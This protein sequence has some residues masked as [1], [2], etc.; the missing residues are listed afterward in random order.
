MFEAKK[1]MRILKIL[2]LTLTSLL[3]LVLGLFGYLFFS[4]QL[5]NTE[6]MHKFYSSHHA[7][8]DKENKEIISK[9]MA[10]QPINSKENRKIG[11]FNVEATLNPSISIKYYT[12]QQGFGVGAYGT[13]IAY[14]EIPP[15]KLYASLEEMNKDSNSMEGFVGFGLLSH[16]WYYFRWELD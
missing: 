13:G 16:N 3:L 6:E 15:H 7:D 2:T 4:T 12:H 11:Y 8:L 1:T 10:G 5:P 9:V 14:L